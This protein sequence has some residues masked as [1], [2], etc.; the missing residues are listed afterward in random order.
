MRELP[1]GRPTF[2]DQLIAAYGPR[3]VCNDQSKA[4]TYGDGMPLDRDGMKTRVVPAEELAF[5]VS[6]R[7]GD[8]ARVDNFLAMRGRRPSRA[9]A[10]NL[11]GH[12]ADCASVEF[13]IRLLS[14]EGII[15]A[16][17]S[18]DRLQAKPQW[19]GLTENPPA[20][21]STSHPQEEPWFR[22]K[23]HGKLAADDRGVFRS[24]VF[25]GLW[26]DGAAVFDR[27]HSARP[28]RCGKDWKP[29]TP[30]SCGDMRAREKS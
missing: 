21:P 17:A 23:E 16:A 15:V 25:P 5:Y 10:K 7:T 13:L 11:G 18:L 12:D 29:N 14:E 3:D 9:R 4:V 20:P 24:Q 26:I 22:F 30:L 2:F 1:S 8:V 28:A 19:K 6:W 27:D